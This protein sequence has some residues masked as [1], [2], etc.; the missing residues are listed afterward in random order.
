MCL[1]VMPGM[2]DYRAIHACPQHNDPEP[3]AYFGQ[4]GCVPGP[5]PVAQAY[6]A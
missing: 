6:V 5:Q 3:T 4:P 2:A 1:P